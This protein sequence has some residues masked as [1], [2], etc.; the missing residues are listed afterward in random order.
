MSIEEQEQKIRA[1]E[2]RIRQQRAAL[3]RLRELGDRVGA[4]GD[5]VMEGYDDDG[6]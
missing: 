3:E 1:L 2:D 4:R 6:K 5:T